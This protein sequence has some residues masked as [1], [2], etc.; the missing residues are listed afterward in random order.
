[1]SIKRIHPKGNV[2]PSNPTARQTEGRGPGGITTNRASQ[3]KGPGGITGGATKD[4][5]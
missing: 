1:M 4:K 2:K 5:K 3:G